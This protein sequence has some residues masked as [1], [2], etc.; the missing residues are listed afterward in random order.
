[1]LGGGTNTGSEVN[2]LDGIVFEDDDDSEYE[3]WEDVLID[4]AIEIRGTHASRKQSST[5]THG[6]LRARR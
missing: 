2:S 1:M 5:K 3:A 6:S 4:T